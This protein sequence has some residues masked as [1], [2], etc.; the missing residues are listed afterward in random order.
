MC[1]CMCVCAHTYVCMYGA[2]P[3]RAGQAVKRRHIRPRM[4]TLCMYVHTY[5]CMCICACMHMY[6]YVAH[7]T[8]TCN[9]W[10]YYRNG[11]SNVI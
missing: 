6:M 7:T 8:H 4:I 1:I 10:R 2:D 5:V 9:N 11:I 3:E